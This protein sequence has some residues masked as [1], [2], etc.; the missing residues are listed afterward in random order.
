MFDWYSYLL[1]MQ[2]K[3]KSPTPYLSVK[4]PAATAFNQ[5]CKHYIQLYFSD[6]MSLHNTKTP[7]VLLFGCEMLPPLFILIL[8]LLEYS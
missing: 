4:L 2:K 1:D 6:I 3:K 8:I 7:E 5:V